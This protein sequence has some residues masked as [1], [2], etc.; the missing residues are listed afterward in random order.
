[1]PSRVIADLA[2]KILDR[3][4]IYSA[5]FAA[6]ISRMKKLHG[7]EPVREALQLL[8]QGGPPRTSENFNARAH[9]IEVER[10]ISR[11][12]QRRAEDPELFRPAGDSVV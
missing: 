1:M 10:A 9:R 5:A 12:L 8:A 6:D 7:D 4:R 2:E 11:L 3:E